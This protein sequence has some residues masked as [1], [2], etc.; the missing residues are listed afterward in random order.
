M[1]GPLDFTDNSV[2]STYNRLVQT[3]GAG[4]YF[5]G[6]GDPIVLSG[7]Q[8]AA[9]AQGDQGAQ[10]HQGFQGDQGSNGINSGLVLFLD[11]AGGAYPQTGELLTSPNTGLQTTITTGSLNI[12]NNY[13]VGTF[14]TQANSLT[15][16]VIVGGI[17]ELKQIARCTT[18]GNLPTMHYGIYSVDADG[19][20]NETLIATGDSTTAT[21]I[22]ISQSSIDLQVFVSNTG[23][24]DLTK[25]LRIKLYV[26]IKQNNTTVTLEYR[27]Q[28]QAV[29]ITTLVANPATGPQ[30]PQGDQGAQGATGDQGAQ[31]AQGSTLPSVQ[32]VTSAAI[33]TPTASDNIVVINAQAEGLT[34]AN[35]TGVWVD[36]QSLIIRIEDNGFARAISYGANYRAVGVTRPTITTAGK[37]TYL[38]ILYNSND[39]RWDIIGVT[40]EF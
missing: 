17:W 37:V 28:T 4:N 16:T 30:G 20:S 9:G 15:S 25:R 13:L 22:P 39:T 38:G 36:G 1:P 18:T 10:G 31:G 8:G 21:F 3:D 14:T 27:D 12:A 7:A 23:L 34:L 24:A 11:T 32:T 26:N 5:N 35:P 6:L 2:S 40:T 33:V 29:L 19:V